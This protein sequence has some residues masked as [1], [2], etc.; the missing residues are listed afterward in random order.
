MRLIFF[1]ISLALVIWFVVKIRS[2]ILEGQVSQEPLT[3]REKVITWLLCFFNPIWGGAI[4]YYSWKKRLPLKAKQANR[5]S[6]VVLGL[7]FLLVIF[8]GVLRRG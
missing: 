4:M 5:I 2:S 8:L 3:L 1:V 6:F 7:Q